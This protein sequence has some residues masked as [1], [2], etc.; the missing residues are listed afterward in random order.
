MLHFTT[1]VLLY[2]LAGSNFSTTTLSAPSAHSFRKYAP[3]TATGSSMK[4]CSGEHYRNFFDE[5]M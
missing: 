4:N 1:Y 2:A 5:K 3:V